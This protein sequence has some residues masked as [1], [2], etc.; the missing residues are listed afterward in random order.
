MICKLIKFYFVIIYSVLFIILCNQLQCT[1]HYILCNQLQCT[2][3]FRG[4]S[5]QKF[6]EL[7]DFRSGVVLGDMGLLEGSWGVRGWGVCGHQTLNIQCVTLAFLLFQMTF[8]P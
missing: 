2:F 6:A 5:S 1:I 3:H 4:G 7:G 8:S